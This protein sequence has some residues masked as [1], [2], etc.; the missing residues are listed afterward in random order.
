MM[1]GFGLFD[2]LKVGAGVALGA[3]L[4]FY[5]AKLIG[6]A[7][8]RAQ[9]ATAALSKSVEILRERNVVNEQVSLADAAALCGDLG[10]SDA[11]QTECVRRLEPVY[12]KPD[13]VG[14][15]PADGSPVR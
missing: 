11:D 14:N 4:A 7:E 1:L 8:G 2:Y 12:A 3:S 13:N 6:R 10:L 9:A 15:D 5:P